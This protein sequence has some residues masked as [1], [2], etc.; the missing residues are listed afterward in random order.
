MFICDMVVR[1]TEEE[2]ETQKKLADLFE[3]FENLHTNE[4]LESRV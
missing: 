3:S 4:F 2:F 1:V